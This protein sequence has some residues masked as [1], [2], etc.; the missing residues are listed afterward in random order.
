VHQGSVFAEKHEKNTIT[1]ARKCK[2]FITILLSK[3]GVV[4]QGFKSL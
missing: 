2:F 1:S 4:C 3:S